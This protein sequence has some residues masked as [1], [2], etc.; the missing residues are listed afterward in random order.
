MQIP[1][2]RQT[3]LITVGVDATAAIRSRG[4]GGAGIQTTIHPTSV[5]FMKGIASSGQEL[6]AA[7]VQTT[8]QPTSVKAVD[9][10][11][12]FYGVSEAVESF[13][14]FCSWGISFVTNQVHSPWVLL[15]MVYTESYTSN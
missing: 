12:S 11:W 1:Q 3:Q 14:G 5:E 15:G 2:V 10:Q 7:W 4:P 6:R 9:K 13:Q 8:I